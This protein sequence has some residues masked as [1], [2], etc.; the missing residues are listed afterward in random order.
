MY[1][2]FVLASSLARSRTIF[3]SLPGTG[4]DA[5]LAAMVTIQFLRYQEGFREQLLKN[6]ICCGSAT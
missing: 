6:I 5:V 1:R 4:L 3:G 2:W